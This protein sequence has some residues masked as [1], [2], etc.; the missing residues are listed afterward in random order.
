LTRQR[1][2][3]NTTVKCRVLK[4]RISGESETKK[5]GLEGVSQ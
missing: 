5:K 4:Q 3:R 2:N 1:S